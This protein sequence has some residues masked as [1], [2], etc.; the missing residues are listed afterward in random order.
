MGRDFTPTQA[1]L[2]RA[3][4]TKAD[5]F[6]WFDEVPAAAV[7][8][9]K[10]YAPM[11][12]NSNFFMTLSPLALAPFAYCDAY[13]RGHF[14]QRWSDVLVPRMAARSI[15]YAAETISANAA[16]RAMGA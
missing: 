1:E 11:L 4:K 13:G 7:Y 8:D 16:S 15:T 3:R 2:A 10:F 12:W 9:G 6:F 5:R 14:S